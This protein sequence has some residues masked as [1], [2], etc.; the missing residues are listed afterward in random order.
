MVGL[1]LGLW[2][3]SLVEDE[4]GDR[5]GRGALWR[6]IDHNS[7]VDTDGEYSIEGNKQPYTPFYLLLESLLFPQR[8]KRKETQETEEYPL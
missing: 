6:G 1:G 8:Q 5:D 4:V 3:V 2:V 7:G